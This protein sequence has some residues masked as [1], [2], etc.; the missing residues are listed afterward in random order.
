MPRPVL[1][2]VNHYCLFPFNHGG[3]LGIRGLYKGLSEWFDINI[4]TF[5]GV[6][7]YP[8]EIYISKHIKVIYIVLPSKLQDIQN[9]M[10]QEYGMSAST[11]IDSSPTVLQWYHKFP[12]I[13]DEVRDIAKDSIVVLA[14]HVFTWNLIKEAC[15]DKHLWYRANNVEYDYKIDTWGNLKCP[16][17]ILQNVYDVERD[18]CLKA[19]KILAVSSLEIDRF[20]SLYKLPPSMKEKF[21]DIHSGY[22]V[23]NL[24]TVLPSK[25]NALSNKYRYTGLFIASDVPHTRQAA[26][27]CIRIAELCPDIQIVLLGSIGKAY[28]GKDIPDNVL[29]TGVVTDEE[30]KRYLQNCD[31]AL[32]IMED[33]AGINV[34]MFEYFAFGIPVIAT[35]YG[36]RGIDVEHGKNIII[37]SIEELI[38]DVRRFCNSSIDQK[39]RI[40]KNA[41]ELLEKKYSWRSIGRNIAKVIGDMYNVTI[42]KHIVSLDEI[43]LYKIKEES[44]YYPQKPFYIRCAGIRGRRCYFVMASHGFKPLA[45]VDEDKKYV[46]KDIDGIPVIT[47]EQYIKQ[48]TD[49]EI[50]V[51]NVDMVNIAVDL[52]KKGVQAEDII[53]HFTNQCITKL[54]DDMKADS[55]YD[56]SNIRNEILRKQA[57]G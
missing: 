45:F 11:V 25:R 35:K 18:C 20:M 6:N 55:Y 33:G 39:D 12:E 10:S 19:E 5:G 50:I 34:K 23:D 53:L 56:V 26:A 24:E 37:T 22:D 14:E 15:T 31:F 7:Y 3:S 47:V 16:Q 4:V 29:L 28:F 8:K 40:A 42:S 27:H 9:R 36:A 38:V 52:L 57:D 48:R 46:G 1:T 30:K 41:I 17:D 21:M 51:A 43:K 32:N 2:A 49:T 44:V 13:V 54:K